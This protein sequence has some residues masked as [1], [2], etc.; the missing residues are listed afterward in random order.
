MK[1]DSSTVAHYNVSRY[2][3]FS[4]VLFFTVIT[5]IEASIPP[6]EV[7]VCYDPVMPHPTDKVK[8]VRTDE[9][10]DTVLLSEN[11]RLVKMGLRFNY[12][13]EEFST[14]PEMIK[15]LVWEEKIENSV[16]PSSA[17]LIK[18]FKF[19]ASQ[20]QDA[21]ISPSS[22]SVTYNKFKTT[23][24]KKNVSVPNSKSSILDKVRKVDGQYYLD[25]E[26]L[27]KEMGVKLGLMPNSFL[28][29]PVPSP[30]IATDKSMTVPSTLMDERM[31]LK[32]KAAESKMKIID[33]QWFYNGNAV[34]AEEA[35]ALGFKVNDVAKTEKNNVIAEVVETTVFSPAKVS[36]PVEAGLVEQQVLVNGRPIDDA[37]AKQILRK[38]GTEDVLVD[39]SQVKTT[40][41]IVR[42][43]LNYD[44]IN[45]S[46][47]KKIETTTI[48]LA[49]EVIDNRVMAQPTAPVIVEENKPVI[50]APVIV[51]E[52]KP[53]ITTTS[54]PI[55][56]E[57]KAV[58]ID[59]VLYK[60][61]FPVNANLGIQE[62][63]TSVDL[64]DDTTIKLD[65]QAIAEDLKNKRE[66]EEAMRLV[67]SYEASSP[68]ADV[69]P[70][71]TTT[72]AKQPFDIRVIDN[73]Y[74]VNGKVASQ[75]EV[76]LALKVNRD[77]SHRALDID[78]PGIV[79]RYGN[80]KDNSILRVMLTNMTD[81]PHPCH[82]H[83]D[84][85]WNTSTIHSHKVST[86]ELPEVME[87][88][89]T[90]GRSNEFVMP[91]Y[92]VVTSEFGPR[93]GR[94]HLG[95]DVDLETGD[96]VRSA[97][98]GEVRISQYSKSYGYVVVVRHYNG[99]ET[100][101]AHLSRLT[102]SP[103]DKV[104]AGDV[105]GLGGN[106]G[107]S[108]GSHLHFEIR[109]KGHAINPREIINFKHKSLKSHVF[110][111]GRSYFLSKHYGNTSGHD[112]SSHN[113]S[114]SKSSSG[115]KYHTIRR[116]DTLSSLS[117]KYGT[118]I[119]RICGYNRISSRTTL[120]V[121][122]KLRVR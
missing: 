112:H 16:E 50:T 29:T 61:G 110:M 121:G 114:A 9:P 23:S 41:T 105:I 96:P 85:S 21:A 45:I 122:R 55:V 88:R 12:A 46:N 14:N 27:S 74:Y 108:R 77:P 1:T 54:A 40:S 101:Y 73:K 7:D 71:T 20:E 33:G 75:A 97:F 91:C 102:K 32:N 84:Y 115:R 119:K 111:A 103:G 81:E 117:K 113:H 87:F 47:T 17:N 39:K 80:E 89:L 67:D 11:D 42:Q 44:E 104:K 66:L 51:E 100:Y 15:A 2:I 3:A 58:V 5:S 95:I 98:E 43:P 90:S 99:L 25:G 4:F 93:N 35:K 24:F 30:K 34:S 118:S 57:S 64:A 120:K 28:S 70:P 86:S 107:R 92:G 31:A 13:T 53:I 52:S 106:T 49:E 10:K 79:Y 22:A 78:R 6:I 63:A 8:D 94:Q 76:Q 72:A 26:P 65:G 116:G 36:Q 18:P 60:D 59:G 37:Q 109:Y 83:Y 68:V 38:V 69:T 62:E 56:E 82:S 48:P 19:N